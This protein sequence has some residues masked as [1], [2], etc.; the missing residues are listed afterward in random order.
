MEAAQITSPW[1]C[2]S[3]ETSFNNEQC[4]Y[5]AHKLRR[6]VFFANW[7]FDFEFHQSMSATPEDEAR[8][9]EL[10]R[11]LFIS[12]GQGG[13]VLHSRVFQRTLA[14]SRCHIVKHV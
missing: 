2:K 9:L 10:S 13:G 1:I 7:F 8:C 6:A 11:T 4:K 5:L 14:S 12:V 3:T